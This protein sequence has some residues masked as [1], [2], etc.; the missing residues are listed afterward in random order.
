MKKISV[1]IIGIVTIVVGLFYAN[2][3]KKTYIYDRNNEENNIAIATVEEEVSQEFKIKEKT[4]NALAIK[5]QYIGDVSDKELEVELVDDENNVLL[6]M[7]VKESDLE[8]NKFTNI[9]FDPIENVANKKLTLVLRSIDFDK[10]NGLSFV[11][12]S[13]STKDMKFVVNN[14]ETDGTLV[15]KTITKRFDLETFVI[16][17]LFIAYIFVFIR[18]LYSLFK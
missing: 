12:N 17:V 6:D 4:I 13:E 3:D 7:T 18:V 14:E 11:K 10:N 5:G 2:I 1:L 8:N 15:F 9:L 16:F